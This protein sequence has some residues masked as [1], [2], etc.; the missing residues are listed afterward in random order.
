MN[1]CDT[2][3]NPGGNLDKNFHICVDLSYKVPGEAIVKRKMPNYH[4]HE[5]IVEGSFQ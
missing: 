2:C 3:G 5:R 1:K 4:R